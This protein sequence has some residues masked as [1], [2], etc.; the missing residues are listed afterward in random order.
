MTYKR[1]MEYQRKFSATEN[2]NLPYGLWKIYVRHQKQKEHYPQVITLKQMDK[3]RELMKKSKFFCSIMSIISKIT[4][5]N[6]Y[7][8]QNS[9]IMIRST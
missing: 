8:W 5:Q 1:Y 7:Q 9:N 3:Q 4:K 2:P 6:G